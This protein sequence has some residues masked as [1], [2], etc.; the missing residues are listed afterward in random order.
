MCTSDKLIVVISCVHY[1][2]IFSSGELMLTSD[3]LSVTIQCRV[4]LRYLNSGYVSCGLDLSVLEYH[5]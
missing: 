5:V 3:F 4:S 1:T 2:C